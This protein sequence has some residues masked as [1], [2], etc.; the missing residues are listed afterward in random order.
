[1]AEEVLRNIGPIVLLGP[2][3]AG[4]GTQ[5]K[6]L[7]DRYGIPQ[8]STGDLLRENVQ[9]R[10][11]LGIRAEAQM[12]RGELVPDNL[13]CDMVA[14]RLRDQDCERGFIL[15][16]FPRTAIQAA[17]FDAFLKHQVLENPKRHLCS[18]IVVRFDVDYN[19]L[20]LRLTGR[21]TC[22]ACGRIY[23]VHLQPPLV[24]EICDVDGSKLI[25]RDDD[26]Y[27]VI[28]ERLATYE[29]QTMPVAEY[30]KK[31]GRLISVNADRPVDE[32]TTQ[33]F[34]E[35]ESHASAPASSD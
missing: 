11:D 6:R 3:G 33:L 26:R 20:S 12:S 25:I 22:P 27:E 28:Q 30:Y 17:W 35:I 4:K 10:T 1:M 29:R 9:R 21:R 32:V 23:N 15:D 31:Q 19:K 34:Q 18:P 14:W 2:P 16:G 13:V 8:I 5:S 24:D 7:S